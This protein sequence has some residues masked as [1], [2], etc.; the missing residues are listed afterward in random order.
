MPHV[1]MLRA[2]HPDAIA[3][4]KAGGCTVELLEN[5]D[6]ASLAEALPRAEALTVRL[7]A[8]TDAVMAAAP[9]LRIVARHGVGYDSVDI[10]AATARGIPV[11]ITPDANAQSVAEHAMMMLLACAR[12]TWTYDARLRQFGWGVVPEAPTFDLAGR[13]ILVI[14]FGRIGGRVARLCAAFGMRV[15]VHD[16]YVAQNTVKGAGFEPVKELHAGLAIADMVTLHVPSSPATRRMVNAGFL[17]GMK[18]GAAFVNTARGTLVDEAALA[19]ALSAGH[20][21][22]AGLDV[23]EEEPITRPI[24][25]L[26]LPNVVISPHS[27]A[28]TAQGMQRMAMSCADSILACFDGRLDPDVCVNPEVLGRGNA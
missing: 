28:S 6:A 15:L 24:A 2:I 11:T 10:A 12:R 20:V 22:C 18:P 13:T 3:A 23:F 1:L 21:G 25:L 26:G 5:P 17:A 19:S 4:L 8:I 7:T 16:P 14:G 27:A 9:N